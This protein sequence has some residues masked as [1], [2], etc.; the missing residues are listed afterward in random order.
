[1]LWSVVPAIALLFISKTVKCVDY[2]R[3]A[4]DCADG[5]FYLYGVDVKWFRSRCY[6]NTF[7]RL[8]AEFAVNNEIEKF[9]P[10]PQGSDGF[11]PWF[12]SQFMSSIYFTEYLKYHPCR[13]KDIEKS[14][15]FISIHWSMIWKFS[16]PCHD[17]LR[18]IVGS[19]PV[20]KDLPQ[21]HVELDFFNANKGRTNDPVVLGAMD[22]STRH[23]IAEWVTSKGKPGNATC[24]IRGADSTC[25]FTEHCDGR[26]P[27][28]AR[29]DGCYRIYTGWSRGLVMPYFDWFNGFDDPVKA[30]HRRGY[31]VAGGWGV[32]KNAMDLRP[33]LHKAILAL[34]ED[35]T[36]DAAY[37]SS[38]AEWNGIA[39]N[40]DTDD[41]DTD[42]NLYWRL[43]KRGIY[44]LTNNNDVRDEIAAY[45]DS[46]FCVV[47][48]GDSPSR[49]GLSTCILAGSIP[50]ICS[51]HFVPPFDSMLPWRQFSYRVPE[52]GCAHFIL[53]LPSLP[54]SEV[55]S[56][57]HNLLSIR[58]FFKFEMKNFSNVE[59]YTSP[60]G[61]VDLLV[62]YAYDKM[63]E[64]VL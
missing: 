58:S 7:P 43:P 10:A 39:P 42:Y 60:G 34:R 26:S 36:V 57:H 29:S 19:S 48:K 46:V 22:C 47:P 25:P 37:T 30:L 41:D 44:V 56:K 12:D 64:P 40:N 18:T 28:C 4:N 33:V 14:N 35:N 31:L 54:A 3:I 53:N 59:E 8:I 52:A 27:E 9:H 13:T 32:K 24:Y 50:I 21:R 11:Y 49:C 20:F 23:P 63:K 38:T 62:R 2:L 6:P 1:M 51:D 55:Q 17:N 15:L 61:P 16:S 45:N 5:Y